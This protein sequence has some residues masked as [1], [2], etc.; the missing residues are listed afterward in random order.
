[1]GIAVIDG[2]I[3]AAGGLRGGASIADFAVYDAAADTWTALPDMPTARDH[4]AAAEIEGRFYAVGGR[5]GGTLFGSLERFDPGTG[6]WTT[7]L[8][9]MPT[10]RGGLMAAAFDGRLFTFGGEGNP[11]NPLGVFPETEAYDPTLD[12]WSRL[13]RMPT[14]RHGTVAVVLGAGI[15]VVGGAERQGFGVSG[16]NEVFVA[17][18][19]MPL[20]VTRARLTGGSHGGRL[21]IRG[22]LA[23]PPDDPARAPFGVRLLADDRVLLSLALPAGTLVASRGG[24]VFRHRDRGTRSGLTRIRLVRRRSG[25]L[26][27]NVV[28]R[29]PALDGIPRDVVVTIE[30]GGENFCGAAR[31]LGLHARDR[32]SA[33]AANRPAPATAGGR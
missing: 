15:A 14:P 26:A 7:G 1:M 23:D 33:V 25:V 12:R 10:A 3:Y 31:L 17:P 24:R 20:E 30:V 11:A 19:T 18:S 28:A 9:P 5:R 8:A 29:S 27:L 6:R 16:V 21:R 2:R 32:A 22:R 4:L 13:T